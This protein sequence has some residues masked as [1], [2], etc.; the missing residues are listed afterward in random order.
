MIN[1]RALPAEEFG[2]RVELSAGE[3]LTGNTPKNRTAVPSA[4]MEQQ[5]SLDHGVQIRFITDLQEPRRPPRPRG[6]AGTYGVAVRVQGI[7][8]QPFVVLNSG[9]KGGESFGVQI[10]SDGSFAGPPAAPRPPGSD[11]DQ[12]ENPRSSSDEEGTPRDLR[13]SQSHGDLLRATIEEPVATGA[14]RQNRTVTMGKSSSLANIAPE[15][16]AALPSPDTGGGDVVTEPLGSV[17][18]LISKF[19]GPGPA[20]GRVGRRGRVPP[21]QRKRSQSLDGRAQRREAPDTAGLSGTQ[22]R[23]GS[24]RPAGSPEDTGTRSQ[25]GSR[26]AEEPLQLKSTPDLLRD[27]R[28]VT[29]PRGTEDPKELIYGILREG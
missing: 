19:D 9:D 23:A 26:A 21:E 2:I 11:L 5:N 20:R 3:T 24:G 15:P 18:S 28:E 22:R 10:K 6:R 17:D 29:Q 7:A 8:G 25:R 4:G 13:R 27:Q 14:T 1:P 16:R 12:P